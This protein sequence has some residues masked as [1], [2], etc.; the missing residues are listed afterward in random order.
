M[1][2]ST[3]E[4]SPEEVKAVFDAN[5]GPHGSGPRDASLQL[6]LAFEEGK[7]ASTVDISEKGRTVMMLNGA[8]WSQDNPGFPHMPVRRNNLGAFIIVEMEGRV[9]VQ[10]H[11]GK[12][13]PADDV[14]PANCFCRDRQYIPARRARLRYCSPMEAY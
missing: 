8:A 9:I 4:L 12:V 7:G 5:F 13:L 11:D 14:G 10:G 1:Y 2:G 3:I 6:H